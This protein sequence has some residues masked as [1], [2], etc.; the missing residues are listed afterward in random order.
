MGDFETELA[1]ID[2]EL[3]VLED[4]YKM[5]EALALADGEI[6]AE[7]AA[8]LAD[9]QE[10]IETAKGA[11][12]TLIKAEAD[13]DQKEAAEKARAETE[14][15]REDIWEPTLDEVA[16]IAVG[17]APAPQPDDE[18]YEGDGDDAGEGSYN[19]DL[20]WTDDDVDAGQQGGD[21]NAAADLR[22]RLD[23]EVQLTVERNRQLD[24]QMK[25]LEELTQAHEEAKLHGPA[26]LDAFVAR[27]EQINAEMEKSTIDYLGLAGDKIADLA[28]QALARARAID[29]ETSSDTALLDAIT[30][31]KAVDGNTLLASDLQAELT[32]ELVRLQDA[33]VARSE[34]Q[35]DAHNDLVGPAQK[36]LYDALKYMK[37]NAMEGQSLFAAGHDPKLLALEQELPDLLAKAGYTSVAEF[38]AKVAAYEGV[39]QKEAIEGAKAAMSTFGAELEAYQDGITDADLQAMLDSTE[40]LRAFDDKSVTSITSGLMP[41]A[42][43]AIAS[44]PQL[45]ELKRF[46]MPGGVQGELK[47]DLARMLAECGSVSELRGAIDRMIRERQEAIE[48]TTRRLDSDPDLVWEFDVVVENTKAH[49]NVGD[50]SLH[51]GIVADATQD[52]QQSEENKELLLAGG[53]MALGFLAAG[54]AGSAQAAAAVTVMAAGA[55]AL[56]AIDEYQ[57]QRDAHSAEVSSVEASL[58]WL[59]IELMLLAPDVLELS[60]FAKAAG[61]AAGVA[62]QSDKVRKA[63]AVPAIASKTHRVGRAA[64]DFDKALAKAD[65]DDQ[66]A[67][68]VETLKARLKGEPKEVVEAVQRAA[69]ARAE[70][71]AAWAKA[72]QDKR[73]SAGLK[74]IVP[75]GQLSENIAYFAYPVCKSI[76]RGVREVD[77]ILELKRMRTLVGKF[78][79][80]SQESIDDVGSL[81]SKIEDEDWAIVRKAIADL[82]ATDDVT[83][84]AFEAWSKKTDMRGQAFVDEILTP[85]SHSKSR[86][87]A[88]YDAI[89]KK[90]SD[91][92]AEFRQNYKEKHGEFPPDWEDATDVDDLD[93]SDFDDPGGPNVI[94]NELPPDR[95]VE[96]LKTKMPEGL[97]DE[98][99]S[100]AY[101]RLGRDLGFKGDA[102]AIEQQARKLAKV[103][104]DGFE[105]HGKE[106]WNKAL[107][108]S[109]TAQSEMEQVHALMDEHDALAAR[110]TDPAVANGPE[111]GQI[112]SRM[113]ELF[114]DARKRGKHAYELVRPLFWDEIKKVNAKLFTD[115]GLEFTGVGPKLGKLNES[116]TIEHKN[117][118]SDNPREATDP[119]NLT[120][121][122]AY[123]NSGINEAIRMIITERM[124]ELDLKVPPPWI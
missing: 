66:V 37:D 121:S 63:A 79:D 9:L 6:D 114:D 45:Q 108:R 105:K 96:R 104:H 103:L 60:A 109:R 16:E 101:E 36:N 94:W 43:A 27:A 84:E 41:V 51:A 59:V 77:S 98:L 33:L 119:D 17:N 5:I 39:F 61:K 15:Q 82:K 49:M 13:A 118:K 31:L 92:I 24:L 38:E 71:D 14:E 80:L 42:D 106:A 113:A 50:T 89:M 8:G 48:N 32:A 21:D 44:S 58:G 53:A 67:A 29:L 56:M 120:F 69:V 11:R 86:A 68:A 52:R 91:E 122:L 65:T 87:R 117:R 78:D 99:A 34:H 81:I 64:G 76:W 28:K 2:A 55:E 74:A 40:E 18:D 90:R 85:L 110:L 57:T 4:S 19:A 115:A 22:K 83:A 1:E 116:V 107:G 123:E 102:K 62:K 46:A 88:E 30:D 111:A 70:G 10:Q 23:T 75:T 112:R 124:V 26:A 25:L 3:L 95:V 35:L 20:N 12:K 73:A 7:E 54:P 97:A 47:V 100:E 93:L 72:I